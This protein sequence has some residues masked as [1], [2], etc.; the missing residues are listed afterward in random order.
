MRGFILHRIRFSTRVAPRFAEAT[1]ATKAAEEESTRQTDLHEE[2][3][4]ITQAL[5][6]VRAV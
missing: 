4:R 3:E 6:E 5:Q 2:I 1:C